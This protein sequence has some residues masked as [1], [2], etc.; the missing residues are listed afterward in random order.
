MM[1]KLTG[2]KKKISILLTFSVLFVWFI[3]PVQI[4]MAENGQSQPVEPVQIQI[5]RR[6]DSWKYLDDG[7]NQ[8]EAWRQINYDD[9]SWASGP[10]P[11]GYGGTVP[12]S[13]V[14]GYGPDPNNKYITTYFRKT[15]E[16]TNVKDI[17]SLTATYVKDDGVVIYI[18]GQEVIRD[19]M[20]DG[21]INFD[22][23]ASTVVASDRIEYQSSIDPS[24]LV[25]G[26][27]V[28]AAEVHQDRPSSSDMYFDFALDALAADPSVPQVLQ[29]VLISCNKTSVLPGETVKLSISGTSNYGLPMDISKATI[30]YSCSRPDIATIDADGNVTVN[31]YASNGTTFDIWANV[32]LDGVEV[33]SN[34]ITFIVEMPIYKDPNAPVEARVAD[35]L[36]RMTL[37]E[38]VGQMVQGEL[39]NDSSRVRPQD[40]I[41]YAIG[42]VL[43]GGDS[44]PATGNDLQS[45]YNDVT[46]RVEASLQSRL[47]IP[48]IYGIDAVH[49]HSNVLEAT[50]FP[51]NIGLGAIAAG[52]E[53]V[54]IDIVKRIGAA[55]AEEMRVTNIPWTFAPCIADPQNIRW[56]RTYEGFSDDI[57]LVAK[58]AVAYV[59]GLQGETIEEMKNPNKAAATVKHYIG[60]G[61][62]DNGANAGNISTMTKEEVAQKLIKPYADAVAAG[63]RTLMPS[64]HSIQ[65]VRM[66]ASKYLLTDVL[67]NQL[68]FDGF[69][70][71]DWNAIAQIDLLED[72]T[73]A[74]GL[75]QQ[76]RAAVNAG[77]D[78]LMQPTNWKQ[79]ITYLKE[80][81]ADEQANPGTGIPM[82]RIDDAVS[83]ILRVKF[84]LG[85]FENPITPNP[86]TNP[87][88]AA[89]MGSAENRALA[90]EAV[91]KSLVLLKNDLVNGKPILSQLK[92]MKKIFVAG[93]SANNIGNQYGGWTIRW[94]GQSG[95][96]E[97][98]G[99][100][101]SLPHGGT[102]ILKGIQ[103]ALTA[104]QTLTFNEAGIGAEG[105][106]V[107]V[108]VVGETPYAEGNGDNLNK[109]KLDATDRAALENLKAAGVPIVMV[110]VSGR[111][112]IIHEHLAD[113]QG[114]VAA[115]LPGTEGN[116]VADVLFGD[117]D[118]VG[119]SP[120]RWPFYLDLLPYKG[121]DDPNILFPTGYGLTKN[122][123]TPKLPEK[124]THPH[125]VLPDGDGVAIPGKVEME[126]FTYINGWDPN[127]ASQFPN[128][129]D[130]GGGKYFYAGSNSSGNYM[131]Y[132][133]NVARAGTYT[134]SFRVA[135][136]A[137]RN[138]AF[139]LTD[140]T[141]TV[142]C[143]ISIPASGGSGG[144]ASHWQT[145]TAEVKFAKP[146]K[147]LLTFT[148]TTNSSF[149]INWMSFEKVDT[150]PV[151]TLTG[152][153]EA[154]YEETF[155]VSIA[156]SDLVENVNAVDM[157]INYD[158]NLFD[159]IEI[160]SISEKIILLEKSD[161]VNGSTRVVLAT[162]GMISSDE[163][164][165]K[166]TFKAK[167]LDQAATG[168]IEV[169][170]V[171]LGV[172]PDGDTIE[173][174][175]AVLSIKVTEYVIPGDLNN[176]GRISIGDL[177]I[178]AYYYQ[179][180]AGDDNWDSAKI[181]D[182]NKD[183]VVDIADLAFIAMRILGL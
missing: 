151:V 19:G 112:L 163:A 74:S 119:R 22:T 101:N 106:D 148:S 110:L 107:A 146:G 79:V 149:G 97:D 153:D 62:T 14:V 166:L 37:D 180:K 178:A 16:I 57:N 51:H 94:Q 6:G 10:S 103:D 115:W 170:N 164:L 121:E 54:G 96:P 100:S 150:L 176:D 162:N 126:D 177:G 78:M 93:K 159:L 168:S 76:V 108:L 124:P 48:I 27:N 171:E 56:G 137:T 4:A 117:Q 118:F 23:R 145:V 86:A 111:P 71:T 2:V 80:L 122:E 109:L 114:L 183:G 59:Q 31:S 131:K 142:L 128:S 156:L 113:V 157:R 132:F 175:G 81:V 105:H 15:F 63:A 8:G 38:K 30:T 169:T 92:D 158:A 42:S 95:N 69:V 182:V 75:K 135:A 77:C 85:L 34:T 44:D 43:S 18:N 50:I 35:L 21:V 33:K 70:I 138:N 47:G 53:A 116:G 20:P 28:I 72:G 120:M 98:P 73:R 104:E 58:L 160:S 167:T 13:T 84:Q 12:V 68:G 90:R 87:E 65:G 66:H 165:V 1:A 102:T 49:G 32:A 7:S 181:A 174:E 25:N 29:E 152:P 172:A 99:N 130:V 133:V 41:D 123:P 179:A 139:T 26:I 155:D 55:T 140:D 82:S 46:S 129:P 141:G 144:S 154:H 83:R 134:A 3:S 161:I 11:L 143:T 147:Q 91:A 61:Y 45:W 64:F 5:V 127:S 173:A 67:K 89:K 40:C 60:E 39:G 125:D 52:N 136:S 9:S 88:V 36:S 17:I 24:Y